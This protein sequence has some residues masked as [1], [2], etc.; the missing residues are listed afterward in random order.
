MGPIGIPELLVLLFVSPFVIV[1]ALAV[2][3]KEA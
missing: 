1:G 3:V 2:Y